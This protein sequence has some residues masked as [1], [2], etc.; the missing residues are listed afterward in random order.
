[1]YGFGKEEAKY[2]QLIT[3]YNLEN[4]VFLR[5]FKRNLNAEIQDAYMS[6]ITSS[7]E[8]FNL[9]LLETIAEGIPSVGY[10]SKYGPSELILNNKNGYLINKMIKINYMIVY[11]TYY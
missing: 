8:G 9:G 5:G 1:M 6:L 7:M 11:E 3:E 2:K 10:N 4:N